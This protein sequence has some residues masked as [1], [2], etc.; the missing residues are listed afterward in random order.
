MLTLVAFIG[1]VTYFLPY[2]LACV[3]LDGNPALYGSIAHCS[4]PAWL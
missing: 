2:F 1:F 4:R 3:V